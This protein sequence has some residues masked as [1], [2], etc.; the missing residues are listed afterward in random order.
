MPTGGLCCLFSS[1]LQH[2][3]DRPTTEQQ[4]NSLLSSSPLLLL[5]HRSERLGF[6]MFSLL[7]VFTLSSGPLFPGRTVFSLFS[8]CSFISSSSSRLPHPRIPHMTRS[9]LREPLFHRRLSPENKPNGACL[10]VQVK[11]P[12]L[13]ARGSVRGSGGPNKLN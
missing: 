1:P 4:E 3:V 7:D 2:I 6:F 12:G 5:L 10:R 11:I 9:I 8:V 13:V